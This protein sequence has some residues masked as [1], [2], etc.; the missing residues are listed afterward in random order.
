MKNMMEYNNNYDYIQ[1]HCVGP[2]D[3]PKKESMP[4]R[5]HRTDQKENNVP[6][7]PKKRRFVM[8]KAKRRKIFGSIRKENNGQPP[9]EKKNDMKEKTGKSECVSGL[10]WSHVDF[11]RAKP[12]Q[13]HADV[14]FV[15]KSDMLIPPT[16]TTTIS[17]LSMTSPQTAM[18]KKI[19]A[20]AKVKATQL[21]AKAQDSYSLPEKGDLLAP[22]HPLPLYTIDEC[23]YSKSTSSD[24][25]D[26][27]NKPRND[28]ALSRISFDRAGNSS[29]LDQY[30]AGNPSKLNI[31][32]KIACMG[33]SAANAAKKIVNIVE[34]KVAECFIP[35]PTTPMNTNKKGTNHRLHFCH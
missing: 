35:T 11:T 4:K 6:I 8:T 30:P 5:S 21:A 2:V 27:G 7:A 1:S 23:T 22:R 24:D 19:L 15:S 29:T 10:Q 14:E 32:Q 16:P 33:A 18:M 9:N 26:T 17:E 12:L 25:Y 13:V 3:E 28:D 31:R 34:D 20:D